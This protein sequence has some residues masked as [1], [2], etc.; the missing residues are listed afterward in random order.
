MSEARLEGETVVGGF[1]NRGLCARAF[2]ALARTII[3]HETAPESIYHFPAWLN[4]RAREWELEQQ[5][6]GLIG[7][8]LE[9]RDP[10]FI[11]Q[12]A[13]LVDRAGDAFLRQIFE[14]DL[15][16]LTEFFAL[17]REM[18]LLRQMRECAVLSQE[19]LQVSGRLCKTPATA[20]VDEPCE[21]DST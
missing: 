19:A 13:G 11:Q 5:W 20:V 15:L 4:T 2:V 7:D 9:G 10:T 12:T 18:A 8:L 14:S 6:R 16:T 17:A 3:A 1:K 21:T